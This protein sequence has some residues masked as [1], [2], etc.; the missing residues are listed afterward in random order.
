METLQS[1]SPSINKQKLHRDTVASPSFIPSKIQTFL[2]RQLHYNVHIHE[3]EKQWQPQHRTPINLVYTL[4]KKHQQYNYT[5]TISSLS[6]S[7]NKKFAAVVTINGFINSMF[8]PQ[9]RCYS[10]ADL[11]C[12]NQT[13][14]SSPQLACPQISFGHN[15]LLYVPMMTME[16]VMVVRE[17]EGLF[18]HYQIAHLGLQGLMPC[19]V[20][21]HSKM[22]AMMPLGNQVCPHHYLP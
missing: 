21:N 19:L 4:T 22:V 2:S 8:K 12:D 15:F 3:S 13:L 1:L 16:M 20:A 5:T 11:C 18:F 10:F 9:Q 17:I 14:R 7:Y 6:L